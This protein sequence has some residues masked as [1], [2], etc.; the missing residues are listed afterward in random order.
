MRI[1]SAEKGIEKYE[2]KSDSLQEQGLKLIYTKQ[3][4]EGSTVSGF[5]PHPRVEVQGEPKTQIV[6]IPEFQKQV[7]P[8]RKRKHPP[9]PGKHVCPYCGRGCAKPSVLQKH[10]RAHT[11]ERPYP[12]IPCGFSFK[13]KSNLYKHR[14]SRTHA[15]KAGQNPDSSDGNKVDCD[16]FESEGECLSD[17]DVDSQED[18]SVDTSTDMSYGS[19]TVQ[20]TSNLQESLKSEIT[21][22]NDSSKPLTQKIVQT[23]SKPDAVDESQLVKNQITA[24]RVVMTDRKYYDIVDSSQ[25]Q[26]VNSAM[27]SRQ[28]SVRSSV[29]SLPDKSLKLTIQVQKAG[30]GGAVSN[31][32]AA[33]PNRLGRQSIRPEIIRERITQLI[34]ENQAIVDTPMAEPPRA[35]RLSR[36]NSEATKSES[37]TPHGSNSPRIIPIQSHPLSGLVAS[38]EKSHG[39]TATTTNAQQSFL[40]LMEAS[41]RPPDMLDPQQIQ[42]S[43]IQATQMIGSLSDPFVTTSTTTT[44]TTPQ[45][46]KIH[47]KFPKMSPSVSPLTTTGGQQMIGQPGVQF[48]KPFT[49]PQFPGIQALQALNIPHGQSS[50]AHPSTALHTG[51]TLPQGFQLQQV[52][53]VTSNNATATTL[54]TATEPVQVAST[55]D[56]SEGSVIKDLLLKGRSKSVPQLKVAIPK[57]LAV[58]QGD[59]QPVDDYGPYLCKECKT[60]FRRPES[61]EIHRQ[62]YCPV[63]RGETSQSA[64][65]TQ[66]VLKETDRAEREQQIIQKFF[67][68]VS[69]QSQTS[70]HLSADGTKII[71][72]QMKD[73]HHATSAGVTIEHTDANLP[74]KKGRPKGSKNK[75]K[76]TRELHSAPVVTGSSM[77]TFQKQL[78]SGSQFP[79]HLLGLAGTTPPVVV[80]HKGPI[81]SAGEVAQA[82]VS[83]QPQTSKPGLTLKMPKISELSSQ[84]QS[85][86]LSVGAGGGTPGTPQPET[87]TAL[88]KLRLKG[89]I[90][91]KRSMSVERMLSQEADKSGTP[92]PTK[93]MSNPNL[94]CQIPPE[95]P[96]RAPSVLKIESEHQKSDKSN[97]QKVFSTE[98]LKAI[99]YT[100]QQIKIV[101]V[102]ENELAAKRRKTDMPLLC[103]QT[104]P[105]AQPGIMPIPLGTPIQGGVLS[106]VAN[107]GLIELSP[108]QLMN[109]GH[110]FVLPGIPITMPMLPVQ[111][112]GV[113]RNRTLSWNL[114]P[115]T[116]H[117]PMTP[118]TPLTPSTP[119]TPTPG[120][121]LLQKSPVKSP[122]LDLTGR[123]QPAVR[124]LLTV[125]QTIEKN[126]VPLMLYGHTYPTL[127]SQTH[128]SF[129]CVQRPQPMYAVQGN[130]RKI[131]MYSNW[132]VAD[133]NP[134]PE[135]LSSRLLL[136]LYNSSQRSSD[137]RDTIAN[138]SPKTGVLTHSSYWNYYN[139]Q[140]VVQSISTQQQ[141]QNTAKSPDIVK[142][143]ETGVQTPVTEVKQ[144][145]DWTQVIVL[146]SSEKVEVE[147]MN[148]DEKR[149]KSFTGGYVSKDEYVYV[150][151]RGR[152]KYV[153][154]EC[155]IRC[156]KPSM[157]KK[158]I[159][160][161][162]DVRP[163]HCKHCK[164]SFKTKGNLTK[165]MKSK[166]HHK[167][168]MELGI[169]PIPVCVEDSQI[170]PDA[171]ARQIEIS[172][173]SKIKQG[174][175][176]DDDDDDEDDSEDEDLQIDVEDEED[177]DEDSEMEDQKSDGMVDEVFQ[178]PSK[179]PR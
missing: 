165:H 156:K 38:V 91:M 14:K 128:T 177:E 106:S 76:E 117:S 70:G 173:E 3:T 28:D 103:G 22:D 16:P 110:A 52:I 133:F 170:D 122:N 168:C 33:D 125:K 132:K 98:G 120:G 93:V 90:L 53:T 26:S 71:E 113:S 139:K 51:I 131:S 102:E 75:P 178:T 130:N 127:R 134:N 87:P 62:F 29:D 2:L 77:P 145:E 55:Q 44:T 80:N 46:I 63:K 34:S 175:L 135:G 136:D 94:T 83:I 137:P 138:I 143:E 123:Q 95:A 171:L 15:L 119:L 61:L 89:K 12:C 42:Q 105:I 68:N 48:P 153:C 41:G 23:N 114:G 6:Q 74:K 146:P 37:S 64:P 65:A 69:P 47:I 176:E 149:N 73:D 155:G 141:K 54:S 179:S 111:L 129:C 116:P 92:T 158:H 96:R 112:P 160:T 72:W 163:Y 157:L 50:G 140:R 84:V 99:D 79:T 154:E 49:G 162:T 20:K 36:Q 97:E 1:P 159:R 66:E 174:D 152:G 19:E 86:T 58:G 115:Q 164:F 31:D 18:D 40:G 126:I 25:V 78:V 147:V 11:G 108:V 169:F 8:G 142:E 172:K 150:R 13:T 88:W 4:V 107:R 161:H 101:N 59:G 104:I 56:S 167:K 39:V 45:E 85:P 67:P 166:A 124:H 82:V 60:S 81:S 43:L 151:G 7:G 32:V 144:K 30:E 17:S 9:K 118:K 10:V 109:H 27:I 21:V 121:S 100:A 57:P 35:K 148:L 5:P 24:S